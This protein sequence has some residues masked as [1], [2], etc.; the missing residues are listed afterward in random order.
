LAAG[1]FIATFNELGHAPHYTNAGYAIRDEDRKRGH[2]KHG[3]VQM[4][5]HVPETGDQ[6][7]SCPLEYRG[8]ATLGG[9]SNTNN[10]VTVQHHGRTTNRRTASH[11][12]HTHVANREQFERFTKIHRRQ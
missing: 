1:D 9:R 5:M 2:L 11:V 8:I 7:F 12:D 10:S 6:K 3:L 4:G